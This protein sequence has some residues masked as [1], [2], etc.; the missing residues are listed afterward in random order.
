MDDPEISLRVYIERIIDE[1]HKLYQT[2]F[3]TMEANTK[4]ALD[5]VKGAKDNQ[6]WTVG[7]LVAIGISL[8]SVALILLKGK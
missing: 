1:R 6:H 8:I 5:T 2:K 3:A 4:L 7:N